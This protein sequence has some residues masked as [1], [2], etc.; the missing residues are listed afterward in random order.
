MLQS[1]L[2]HRANTCKRCIIQKQGTPPVSLVA[3]AASGHQAIV[4]SV[5]AVDQSGSGQPVII[6]IP[7]Q[8][9]LP[10]LEAV[11]NHVTHSR[12][13]RWATV[14]AADTSVPAD[15]ARVNVIGGVDDDG[16]LS[17][18][19]VEAGFQPVHPQ[20]VAM[21]AEVAFLGAEQPDAGL[22]AAFD[23]GEPAREVVSRALAM[24]DQILQH[25]TLLE[26]VED[27]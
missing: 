8:H 2:L 9:E 5:G 19:I 27:P 14:A 7:G 22:V 21:A 10:A 24:G 15:P 11:N 16:P 17:G 25:Q 3:S 6:R 20:G 4:S 13:Y 26:K 12:A 23:V 1:T 18:Q